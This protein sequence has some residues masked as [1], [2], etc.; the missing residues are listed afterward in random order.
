MWLTRFA[1]KRSVITLMLFGALIVFGFV[2]FLQLGRSTAPPNTNFPVVVVYAGYPGASPQDMERM[3]IKPVEDQMSGVEHLDELDATAQEGSAVVVAI[4]KMG[5]DLDLAAIDVQRRVDTARVY[6]PQDMNPPSV[7]KEGQS[8]PP[9]LDLAVSS[10]SLTQPQIADV[11]NNQVAPLIQAIPNVQTVDVYGTADREF[12]VVPDPTRLVGTNATLGDVFSAISANNLDV[13][14]GMMTQ[15]TREATVSIYSYINGANDILGIPM[16][17]P[18]SSNRN[19]RIGDVAASL[20][21]HVEMRTISH[22]NGQPRVRMQIN[23]T[24]G[25][26]QITTTAVA[27]AQLKDIEAKFPQ[28]VFTE[29][30]APAD[31][32][33]QQLSGVGISLVQGIF[34]TALVMLLFLHAWR[35]AVVV[36]LAIPTSILAT[37]VMMKAFGFHIDEMSMMGLALII[38]ILVDDSIVVLEN[39]TRHRDMG[40]DAEN[41]AITGRS[42]IGSAAIAITLVDVIVFVPLVMM[43][44]IVGAYLKEFAAVVVVATLFSLLVS[45]TLTPLLAAVW[46]VKKRSEAKPSWL[47]ALDNRT[48]DAVLFTGAVIAFAAGNFTGWH[49]LNVGAVFVVA[50]LLCNAFVQRYE[51]ILSSYRQ[52]LL[53]WALEHG[54][55]VVFVCITLFLNAVSLPA[56]GGMTTIGIDVAIVLALLA[57]YGVNMIVRRRKGWD[58]RGFAALGSNVRLA[59][60]TLVLP[61]IVGGLVFPFAVSSDAFPGS[62]NGQINMVVDYPAGTPIATTD[63][64]VVQLENAI[65]K[66]D[67]IESVSSNVGRK[68]SG[69]GSVTGGNFATLYASMRKDRI[70]DTDATTNKIRQ[71][72]YLV[73]GGSLSVAGDNGNGTPIF[74]SLTGPDDEIGPAAEK[75]AAYLRTIPGSAN[76]QTSAEM[77]SPRLNVNIDRAKCAV[78]GVNPSEAAN[79]A[80]IAVDGAVATRVRTSTGLVDVRVQFPLSDRSTVESLKNVRIRAQDGTLIPLGSVATFEWTIAPTKIERMNRQRIVNVLGDLMP[81]Y[82]LGQVEGPLASKLREPGF[83]PQGVALKAEGDSQWAM[84]ALVNMLIGLVV[85]FA[86]VYMLMVILYGSFLEPVIVMCSVPLA[87]IGALIF[88]G[89]LGKIPGGSAQSLNIIS[90][91]GIIMLFGL[92]AKNG[93]LL[94]D[95]SN[96]LCKRGM[97]VRDAVLQ[98][99]ST[100]FRPIIM[101]TAAMIFGMLPLSLGYDAGS[102]WRQ[103]I[104][105]VIIGGLL[106]S[107][108]LTLFLIPMIYNSWMGALERK[109]D[110]KAVNEEL[111]PIAAGSPA[112]A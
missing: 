30:D 10:N 111:A 18:G 41:A 61:L 66:I 26:D 107:L 59:V 48:L 67:G 87:V 6:M 42:E 105:T 65:R 62:Q 13:P 40:L 112:T 100:R 33:A 20:D 76:V 58:G 28:L 12:H 7:S 72:A 15:P 44:G 45:F 56:G 86:L 109:A 75:V 74:Y 35:N 17:V 103:A 60:I 104:G 29:I 46:S 9:L 96:T 36:F 77:G 71:L 21:D 79:I 88:L 22:F 57:T 16:A 83:L 84:E 31:E 51:T 43:S 3:V 37:F 97:R 52:K 53:P 32:T 81:G 89:V 102:E 4:F 82:A 70:K 92:V 14:G 19:L 94:V 106:S 93:I 47:L 2:S 80:R 55:F 73:P 68:Q 8:E 24:L 108:V 90:F 27:R 34:L 78:L 64:Y 69:H 95:Y 91:L 101:T 38:G 23:P 98:A 25:A 49:W 5:T 54:T 99:A 39:I 85:S 1:I 110:R 63:K 50:A 11:I